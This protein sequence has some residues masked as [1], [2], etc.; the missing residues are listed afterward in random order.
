MLTAVAVR[1]QKSDLLKKH[2]GRA[3]ISGADETRSKNGFGL[4]PPPRQRGRRRG[5]CPGPT[6]EEHLLNSTGGG[7]GNW[8]EKKIELGKEALQVEL[9]R[10]PASVNY[11]QSK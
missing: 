1:R 8:E 11:F 3:L 4:S 9:L 6:A 7:G 2:F 5:R 10:L